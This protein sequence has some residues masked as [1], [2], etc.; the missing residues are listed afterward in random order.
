M[1]QNGRFSDLAC[2]ETK[3][4]LDMGRGADKGSRYDATDERIEET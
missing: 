2:Y 4:T 1:V 3:G